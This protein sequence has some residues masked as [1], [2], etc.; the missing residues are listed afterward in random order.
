[1]NMNIFIY[2]YTWYDGTNLIG[3]SVRKCGMQ[4][5]NTCEIPE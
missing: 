5:I 1:M 4:E 2:P 3:L